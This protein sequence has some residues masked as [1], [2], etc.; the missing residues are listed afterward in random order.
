VNGRNPQPRTDPAA[1][2]VGSRLV[3]H[4]GGH[5]TLGT[6]PP[7]RVRVA[8]AVGGRRSRLAEVKPTDDTLPWT[9]ADLETS[10]YIKPATADGLIASAGLNLHIIAG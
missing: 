1:P 2:R 4:Y 7:R 5:V 6:L 3:A 8:L 9:L 10:R